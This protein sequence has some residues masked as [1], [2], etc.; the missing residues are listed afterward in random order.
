MEEKEGR[1]KLLINEALLRRGEE[2]RW[3]EKNFNFWG[4]VLLKSICVLKLRAL[5]F[6]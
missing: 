5:T 3:R 6:G 2:E 1:E 4:A